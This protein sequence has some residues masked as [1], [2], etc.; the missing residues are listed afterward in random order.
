[1]H[2]FIEM[3]IRNS[4]METNMKIQW[5]LRMLRNCRKCVLSFS[6]RIWRCSREYLSWKGYWRNTILRFRRHL[7]VLWRLL[8]GI[9]IGRRRWLNHSRDRT[10]LIM[11][12]KIIIQDG[13]GI[14]LISIYGIRIAI[15]IRI[16]GMGINR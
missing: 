4:W 2:I 9:K 11:R 12:V 1:M 3:M 14:I 10:I 16:C 6:L 8:W 13:V 5:R 15:M 7:L